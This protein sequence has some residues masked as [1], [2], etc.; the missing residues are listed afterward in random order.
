M[1]IIHPFINYHTVVWKEP[2]PTGTFS[3][4]LLRVKNLFKILSIRS[5]GQDSVGA[6]RTACIEV[7]PLPDTALSTNLLLILTVLWFPDIYTTSDSNSYPWSYC[8]GYITYNLKAPRQQPACSNIMAGICVFYF[9]LR[10]HNLYFKNI[11]QNSWLHHIH[12]K[13]DSAV[14]KWFG[15]IAEWQPLY[16]CIYL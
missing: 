16:I 4:F 14:T 9:L 11:S 7:W 6:G 15:M 8:G 10:T 12:K 3:L 2:P 13:Q 5:T 1:H